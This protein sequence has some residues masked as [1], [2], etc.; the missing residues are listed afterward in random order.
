MHLMKRELTRVHSWA[1]G[2]AELD[3]LL[4]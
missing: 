2:S 4:T 1:E 3:A